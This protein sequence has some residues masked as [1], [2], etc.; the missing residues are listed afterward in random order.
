MNPAAK[1]SSIAPSCVIKSSCRR[2]A[3]LLSAVFL[4]CAGALKVAAAQPEV[5]TLTFN[6]S[7]QQTPLGTNGQPAWLQGVEQDGGEFID[8]PPCWHASD[9]QPA[10]R[11][12]LA[13]DIDH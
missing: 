10:G 8:N 2:S 11:G 1:Q 5:A 13:L 6:S 3:A 4:C 12:R 9:D 7:S